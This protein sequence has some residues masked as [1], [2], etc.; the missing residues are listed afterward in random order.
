MS[1]IRSGRLDRRV[2]IQRRGPDV[3]DG[4]TKKPGDWQDVATRWAS[5]KPA[6]GREVM[7]AEGQS[8][9]APMSFWFR[10]DAVTAGVTAQMALVHD[11]QRYEITAPAMEVGRRQGIE[12]IALASDLANASAS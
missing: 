3:D 1:M 10:Y 9:I 12:V 8:G 11:G 7:E 4:Y 5:V 2:T 6:R